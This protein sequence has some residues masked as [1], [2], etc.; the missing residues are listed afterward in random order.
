MSMDKTDFKAERK[1]LYAPASKE[2][3][4]VDVPAFDFAMIDGRGD[5]NTSPAYAD[6]VEALYSISYALKFGSKRELGKDYVVAP[7]EGLWHGESTSAFTCASK[8]EWTWTMMVRRPH[9]LSADMRDQ[10]R[11]KVAEKKLPAL[12]PHHE[13]YLSDPRKVAAA[14]LRTILRQPV[15]RGSGQESN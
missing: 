1:D 3:S 4:V 2:F 8:S 11:A 10:A 7:L 14:K 13:I 15:R 12:G 5:P 9:W 6:A